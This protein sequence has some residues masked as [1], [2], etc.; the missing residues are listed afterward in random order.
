[1]NT[2]SS[3]PNVIREYNDSTYQLPL[4][5]QFHQSPF[6]QTQSPDYVSLREEED[7]NNDK[8]LDIMS[9]CIVDSV[10]YKSQN[11]WPTIESNIQ[12]EHS[13]SIDYTRTTIHIVRT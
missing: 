4:N 2:F 6:L 5:S 1:M 13:A 3:P 8:N 11:C 9:S 12:F 10:I 7:D